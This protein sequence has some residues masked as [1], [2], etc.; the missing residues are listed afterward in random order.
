MIARA[1]SAYIEDKIDARG[2]KSDFLSY[3]SDNRLPEYR[4]WGLKPF[5]EAEERIAI[6][7]ALDTLFSTLE[8]RET[9]KGTALFAS[10]TPENSIDWKKYP[11]VFRGVYADVLAGKSLAATAKA[12]GVREIAVTN[13]L[14]SLG[15]RQQALAEAAAP[16]GLKPKA[17]AAGL[18]EPGRPE[19]AMSE[20]ARCR[21]DTAN[22]RGCGRP[23]GGRQRTDV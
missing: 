21:A 1:F 17:N 2:N 4:M 15:V 13:I 23:G 14:K 12:N 3:G 10:P 7:Q 22:S 6:N 8:T 18:L 20:F 5:P 16:G 19:R 11:P 9:E